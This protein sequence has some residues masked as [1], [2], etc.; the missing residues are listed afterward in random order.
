MKV[1][2]LVVL[3]S[4]A[5]WGKPVEHFQ[6]HYSDVLL[7][8]IQVPPCSGSTVQCVQVCVDS[9]NQKQGSCRLLLLH[10]RGLTAGGGQK[11]TETE[12]ILKNG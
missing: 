4:T 9:R 2:T 12:R 6:L 8:C 3:G 11:E 1:E 5:N 10:H 7:D